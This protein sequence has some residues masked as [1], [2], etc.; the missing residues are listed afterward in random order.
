MKRDL[1]GKLT[2]RSLVQYPEIGKERWQNA[3]QA[4][5]SVLEARAQQ[6]EQLISQITL[7]LSPHADQL[8]DGAVSGKFVQFW[9]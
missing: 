3:L 1:L 6:C 2:E 7:V 9:C 8:V 4:I 5:R